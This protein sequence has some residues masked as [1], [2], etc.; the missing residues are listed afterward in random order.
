MVAGKESFI[1][2]K[3]SPNLVFRSFR[4]KPRIQILERS[5]ATH[6]STKLMTLPPN[7]RARFRSGVEL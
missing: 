1:A 7:M 6:S 2:R 3:C 5:G 4:G